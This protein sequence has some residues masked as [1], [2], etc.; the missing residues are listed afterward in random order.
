MNIISMRQKVAKA[1][2]KAP[3]IVTIMRDVYIVSGDEKTL[4]DTPKIVAENVEGL[5]D[6]S[7]HEKLAITIKEL[8]TLRQDDDPKFYTVY[9]EGV[10]FR[11][12]DYFELNGD[13]YKVT[14]AVNILN[15]NIY[16]ELDLVIEKPKYEEIEVIEPTEEPTE[17]PIDEPEETTGET[18]E[19][20]EPISESEEGQN[21][22]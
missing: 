14:N 15:L 6:N 8:G 7:T 10:I 13:I 12:G 19:T 4:S 1:I 5:L 21:N 20:T 17:E 16:W 2:K 11:D 9:K 18:K 3:T 22:G